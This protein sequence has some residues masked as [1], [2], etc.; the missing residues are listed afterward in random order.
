MVIFHKV[1][2]SLPGV[3]V[4][5]RIPVFSQFC[6]LSLSLFIGC[7]IVQLQYCCTFVMMLCCQQLV[8][9]YHTLGSK[10]VLSLLGFICQVQ[11]WCISG[12]YCHPGKKNTWHTLA[13]YHN[14]HNNNVDSLLTIGFTMVCYSSRPWLGCQMRI[15][16]ELGRQRVLVYVSVCWS[17]L[18]KTVGIS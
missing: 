1:V 18:L 7:K 13:L 3:P 2:T 16:P 17:L 14:S 10:T 11:I 5:L 12:I 8:D 6:Y 4:N 15:A 9:Y